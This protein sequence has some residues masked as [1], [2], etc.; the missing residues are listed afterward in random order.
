MKK[1]QF[2][3]IAKAIKKNWE[4]N[5]KTCSEQINLFKPV[6]R[7]KQLLLISEYGKY[8][9]KINIFN[10]GYKNTIIITY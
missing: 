2:R 6:V 3:T 1:M 10:F 4:K 8:L 9:L 5:L 7:T